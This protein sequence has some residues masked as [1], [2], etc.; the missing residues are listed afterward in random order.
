[1]KTRIILAALIIAVIG[2][3]LLH[4]TPS[5]KSIAVRFR[6]LIE[7]PTGRSGLVLTSSLPKHDSPNRPDFQNTYSST[8]IPELS[9]EVTYQLS[10]I[11]QSVAGVG[12][13]LVNTLPE[14]RDYRF[15]AIG[16]MMLEEIYEG[17]FR[18]SG[19]SNINTPLALAQLSKYLKASHAEPK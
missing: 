4:S 15:W 7:A 14:F 16:N 12:T 3:Y 8:N 18:Q 5:R 9:P 11:E 10:L 2:W 6:D 13:N 1:M 17:Q 19:P